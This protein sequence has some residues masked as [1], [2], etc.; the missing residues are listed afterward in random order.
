MISALLMLGLSAG[1]AAWAAPP[2]ELQKTEAEARVAASQTG[3]VQ[4]EPTPAASGFSFLALLQTRAIATNVVPTNALLDGQIIGRLGGINQTTVLPAKGLDLDDD[5][6]PDERQGNTR[7]FEQ[8]LSAFFTYAPPVYDGRLGLTTGFEIDFG[9]G[10]QS[11]AQGG[12]TGGGMGADQVNLQTRRLHANYKPKLWKGH[13][14]EIVAGLQFVSDTV[15]NPARARPD[16][17]FRSGGGIR[18][19]GTE[20]AGVSAFGS[21]ESDW[22]TWMQYRIGAYK[23]W[24]GGSAID[25][26]ADLLMLDVAFQPAH[27][28]WLGLHGWALND[29]TKGRGSSLV[30]GTGPA[31]ALSELQGG[32]A[33]SYMGPNMDV[34][35]EVDV[36]V[37]WLGADLGWNHRLDRGPIG[38]TALA[39]ANV[40]TIYIDEQVDVGIRGWLAD[41]ELRARYAPGQGSVVRLGGL[42]SSRDGTGRDEYTGIITGNQYGVV[43]AL[44]ATSG[45]Y[46]LFPDPRSINRLTPVVFDLSNQGQG[47]R[48]TTASI[49]YDPIPSVLNV[50]VGGGWA[51]DGNGLAMGTEGNA[52]VT[53]HPFLFSDLSLAYARVV[54]SEVRTATNRALADDPWTVI[55]SMQNLFF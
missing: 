55:L 22:G 44:Y 5:G 13:E 3:M 28:V 9:W 40:G 16:D 34:E 49:G 19:W 31:S 38:L 52:A 53:W 42:A 51:Q 2:A 27:A 25:D 23:P 29:Q 8:R 39:V 10:D 4:P 26:D 20:M 12:N 33:L 18:F 21:Q 17:L 41:A 30:F 36:Q 14:L 24:E 35:P 6:K 32:P 1:P 43:G 54:G 50:T 37:A 11:Y 7:V 45:C 15:H 47:V 46:L 48:G